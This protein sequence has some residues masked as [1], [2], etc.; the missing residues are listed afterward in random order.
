MLLRDPVVRPHGHFRL[1]VFRRGHLIEV[2]DEA[3][4]VVGGASQANAQLVGGAVTGNSITQIAYGT[5]GT[6]PVTGNTAITAP[7]AKSVDGVSYPAA[8]QAAF[9]FSLGSGEANGM[10]IYEFGLL[11]TAGVLYARKVRTVV[12]NKASDLSFTGTWTL[13]F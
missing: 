11:T 1:N 10:G 2:I 4:L 9:A 5:N 13:S 12:L 7:Y 8:N 3:N 6:A